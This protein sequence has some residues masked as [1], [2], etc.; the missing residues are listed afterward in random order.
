MA[1]LVGIGELIQALADSVKDS[2]IGC[3]ADVKGHKMFGVEFGVAQDFLEK[4]HLRFFLAG[5]DHHVSVSIILGRAK[6]ILEDLI[7]TLSTELRMHGSV[8]NIKL[9]FDFERQGVHVR[10]AKRIKALAVANQGFDFHQ[11]LL[12]PIPYWLTWNLETNGELLPI[13]S[14]V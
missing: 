1:W 14:G 7:P 4:L 3:V 11:I 12:R 9:G 2:I 10:V 13:S 5:A 6:H 8:G